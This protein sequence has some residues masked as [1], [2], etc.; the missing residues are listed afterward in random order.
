MDNMTV[1]TL[2]VFFSLLLLPLAGCSWFTA[3]M[4]NN[5]ITGNVYWEGE[6]RIQGKVVIEKGAV[7]TI[8]PGTRVLFMP[9]TD[10]DPDR[11]RGPHELRGSKLMVHGQLIARGTAYE[12]ITFSYY[13]P[14]A[15]AGSWGGIKVQDAEEVYFYN[16]VFRQAMNAIHSCRSWVSIEYCKFEDNQVGILFHNA[17]LF[18]ERNL[19]RNNVTGI[20]YL[21]GEP[22]ISQNRIADNDNG[23]VIADASQEYLIKDNSFIENRSYNVGLGERVRRKVD[24]RKNYWGAGSA[25]SLELKLFDGRSSLWKGEINYL[26]MRSE[27]VIL[28][29][30][31]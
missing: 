7:L 3:S 10:P 4:D 26:P 27:P 11:K 8:A 5:V 2:L 24:L 9:Y 20:Y 13:D 18:I 12:P 6:V 16:C 30:M 17:R 25:Q 21:S 22:V 15:P 31:E 14:N 23:L 28:S 1:R 19:V 29:G